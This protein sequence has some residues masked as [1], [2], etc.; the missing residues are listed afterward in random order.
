VAGV[1]KDLGLVL[2]AAREVGIPDGLLRASLA[3]FQQASD[4]GHG[5]DDMSAVAESFR[6][7]GLRAPS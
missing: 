1:V 4:A 5:G 7:S 3:A 6:G 2:A